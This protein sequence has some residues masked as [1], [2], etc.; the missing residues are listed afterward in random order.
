MAH[1]QEL[2]GRIRQLTGSDS[3][4]TEKKMFGRLACAPTA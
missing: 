4:L 3:E 1:D 2:A